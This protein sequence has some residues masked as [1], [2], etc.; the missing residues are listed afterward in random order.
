M[1]LHK[2][3]E[4]AQTNYSAQTGFLGCSVYGNPEEGLCYS[5]DT[6]K[7]ADTFQLK[8]SFDLEGHNIPVVSRGS[9][10]YEKRVI[11]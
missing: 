4:Y 11:A 6:Q 1:D 8:R 2:L 3:A 5:F 9:S 7:N 10:V